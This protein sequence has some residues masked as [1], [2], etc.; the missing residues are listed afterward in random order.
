MR[1]LA[2]AL[3]FLLTVSFTAQET[4]TYPYNPD[5][6]S[7]SYVGITDLIELLSIYSYYFEAGEIMVNDSTLSSYLNELNLLLEAAALPEGTSDGQFLKWNGSEWVLV[8]PS[9]GCTDAA[10][11][12]YNIDATVNDEDKCIYPDACGV[13][14]GP[15]EIYE[16][17]CSD[18]PEGD[19][20]CD[21]NQIDALNVCG[22]ECAADEDGDGICDDGDSCIGEADECGVCNG[23]GAIYDCGCTEPEPDTCDCEGNVVDVV[24]ECGGGCQEDVDADGICDSQDDCVGEFDGCGVCN[25]P[26]PILG[27]GCE[28]IPAGD[29][30]CQGNQLDA[31]G[32]CGGACQTDI[33]GDGVCDDD[34]IPGCTYAAACNFDP[35]ASIN[36][37]SCDF[38]NCYGCTDIAACNYSA[39]ATFDNQSCWYAS[40]ALD[41]ELNC[42]NDSDGDGY[43]DELEIYGCTDEE[44]ACNYDSGATELDDSCTYPG[45]TDSTFC[46]YNPEAGCD[47]GSCENESCFGCTDPLACN[48]SALATNDDGTCDLVSCYGCTNSEAC[49]YSEL[50]TLDDGSC[51]YP[52]CTNSLGTNYDPLAGCDDGSCIIE[53]CMIDLACNY[54]P[55]ANID[56]A[57]CEFGNC[58]GCNDSGATNYNP[59]ST[60][61]EI[62]EYYSEFAFT[63]DV[64]TYIVPQSITSITVQATGGSGGSGASGIGGKGGRVE[65]TLPVS[66]GQSLYIFVGGAGGAPNIAGYNGGGYGHFAQAAGGGGA[67]DIRIGTGLLYDR[68]VV[69]GGGGGGGY[70]GCGENGG[71]GGNTTGA[72]SAIGCASVAA[73]GGTP[74]SGGIGAIY[75]GYSSGTNGSF[76]NG[77]IAGSGTGGAGGGGG[78]YGGGGG[79]WTGGGG[80]SSYTDPSA[81]NVVH[82]QGYNTGDGFVIITGNH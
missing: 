67:T 19:C 54:E 57:S 80:G 4:I 46:N 64:Q 24:G 26:G 13:C 73:G 60:N 74:S 56:D 12:N 18:T 39:A 76:G 15:G 48:F 81:T 40:F 10:A 59:T 42:L 36:D 20:D 47:D 23:P 1:Y 27:C 32:T 22:G 29:C 55:T 71:D 5:V 61:D 58:P 14:D 62:C 52:G 6:D 66:P 21:G 79:S 2:T 30:D 70:N 3:V 51:V 78:W 35:S 11:C 41:C 63:G 33:N 45:C 31:V 50:M 75:G 34:S 65:T 82:T 17:G 28:N 38:T 9:V 68:I 43:C 25:G 77:G 8:M 16:C 7:D 53:G 69:A 49:N 44:Y 37:G 72:S